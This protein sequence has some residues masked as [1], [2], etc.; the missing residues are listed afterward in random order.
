VEKRILCPFL[1]GV[2]VKK[3]GGE[4]KLF[5]KK[6]LLSPEDLRSNSSTLLFFSKNFEKGGCVWF[7]WIVG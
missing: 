4:E 3:P 1:G 5:A 2:L 6:F 7:G